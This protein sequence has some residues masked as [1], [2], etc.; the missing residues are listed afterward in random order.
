MHGEGQEFESPLVHLGASADRG[1]AVG[2][3]A[4][5]K[6]YVLGV[7]P[8]WLGCCPVKAEVGGS[9]PLTPARRLELE[10]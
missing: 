10:L 5:N 2:F 6:E 7:W 9:I 3:L 1:P 8:S 4:L